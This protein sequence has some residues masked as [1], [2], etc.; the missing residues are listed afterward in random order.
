MVRVARTHAPPLPAPTPPH[1]LTT[2]IPLPLP[3]LPFPTH[4]SPRPQVVW[5]FASLDYR[6]DVMLGA[7]AAQAQRIAPLFKEQELSNMVWAYGKLHAAQHPHLVAC[8]M[9]ETRAKLH[10]FLPQVREAVRSGRL[11]ALFGERGG[12]AR[13]MPS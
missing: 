5:A 2:L 11:V 3:P 7:V 12:G 6:D 4:P 10:A 13:G 8:L 9:A 1:P